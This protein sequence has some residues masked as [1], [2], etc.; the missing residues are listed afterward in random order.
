[1]HSWRPRASPRRQPALYSTG[2]RSRAPE[3]EHGI[4]SI[5]VIRLDYRGINERWGIG[6]D[7]DHGEAGGKSNVNSQQS[8]A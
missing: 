7:G 6:V 3:P 4:G 1:M 5:M 2:A 8:A